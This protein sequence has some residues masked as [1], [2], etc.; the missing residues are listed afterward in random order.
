[1][2]NG[3]NRVRPS[4]LVAVRAATV[5]NTTR[6]TVVELPIPIGPPPTSMGGRLEELRSLIARLVLARIKAK[7]ET[8]PNRVRVPAK[9]KSGGSL[10]RVIEVQVVAGI[11]EGETAPQRPAV[12]AAATEADLH[13]VPARVVRGL[14]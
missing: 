10:A 5:G 4:Q 1:M 12:I 13:H 6:N 14:L 3:G 9:V 7:L 11:E 8:G 2:R